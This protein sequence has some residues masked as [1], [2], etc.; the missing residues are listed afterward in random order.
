MIQ[1]IILMTFCQVYSGMLLNCT[2]FWNINV[3]LLLKL[4]GIYDFENFEQ[5]MNDECFT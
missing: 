3:R 1:I 4:V 2:Y 5:W